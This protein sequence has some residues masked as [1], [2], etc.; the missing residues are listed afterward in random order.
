[1]INGVLMLLVD[2]LTG[3]FAAR[4]IHSAAT[5]A[6]RRELANAVTPPYPAATVAPKNERAEEMEKW[7]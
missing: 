5:M 2:T 6:A 1:M 7:P 3:G 4:G